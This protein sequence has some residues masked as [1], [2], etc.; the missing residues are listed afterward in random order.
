MFLLNQTDRQT[1]SN[2]KL[3]RSGPEL[4]S[5]APGSKALKCGKNRSNCGKHVLASGNSNSGKGRQEI[6]WC[7]VRS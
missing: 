3:P 7:T 4:Q 2:F 6:S 1:A 5:Q